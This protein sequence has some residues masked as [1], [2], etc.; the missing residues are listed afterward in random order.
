M[1]DHP[2][3][4]MPDV[5]WLPFLAEK[6]WKKRVAWATQLEILGLLKS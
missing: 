6:K 4:R 1:S 5:L 2:A 3:L